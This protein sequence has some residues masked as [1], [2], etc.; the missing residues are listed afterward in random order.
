[1]LSLLKQKGFSEYVFL[2]KHLLCVKLFD[3]TNHNSLFRLENIKG[4]EHVAKQSK[5]K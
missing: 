5:Q 4:L 3:K 2:Q 1:M